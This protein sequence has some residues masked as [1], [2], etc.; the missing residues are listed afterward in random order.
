MVK[1]LKSKFDLDLQP[2]DPKFNRGPPLVIVNTC[3]V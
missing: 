2:F 3:E 1:S